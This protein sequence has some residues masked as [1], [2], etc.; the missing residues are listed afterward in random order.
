MVAS[1]RLMKRAVIRRVSQIV[2]PVIDRSDCFMPITRRIYVSL[3]ADAHLPANLNRLKWGI[4]E[5][6][7]K[8]GF[9]NAWWCGDRACE[10]QILA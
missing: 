6:I 9:L 10:D 4:V 7:E 1:V 2:T 3:P 5:E 8:R